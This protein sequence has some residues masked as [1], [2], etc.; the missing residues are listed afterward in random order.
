MVTLYR[1]ILV[2]DFNKRPCR[3]GTVFYISVLLRVHSGKKIN[4]RHTFHFYD[5]VMLKDMRQY[6]HLRCFPRMWL[7]LVR[8]ILVHKC[9]ACVPPALR[10]PGGHFITVSK[11]QKQWLSSLSASDKDLCLPGAVTASGK[12]SYSI[13]HAVTILSILFLCRWFP[14]LCNTYKILIYGRDQDFL[15]L[16]K[17]K[18]P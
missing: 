11:W 6:L 17:T 14:M 18:S 3:R 13:Y 9:A 2:T 16:T 10:S 8:T 5:A 1:V 7:R 4:D 15:E 12:R